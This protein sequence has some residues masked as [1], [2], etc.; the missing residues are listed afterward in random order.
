MKASLRV[1][2]A[3]FICACCHGSAGMA[4]VLSL[5]GAT[6]QTNGE[7]EASAST[8][9]SGGSKNFN[10]VLPV[11]GE[12]LN[13]AS[14]GSSAALG[15]TNVGSPSP[16]VIVSAQ[17]DVGLPPAFSPGFSNGAS[18]SGDANLEYS[19][20]VLGPTPTVP[21]LVQASG[22]LVTSAP[23]DAGMAAFL[24]FIIAGPGV[25]INDQ[26]DTTVG[27]L[28]NAEILCGSA[29]CEG[30]IRESSVYTFETD[31]LYSVEIG[32]SVL[33]S[34]TLSVASDGTVTSINAGLQSADVSMDPFFSVPADTPSA[35]DYSFVFSAGIGNAPIASI[36]ELPVWALLSVGFMIVGGGWGLRGKSAR[37][38]SQSG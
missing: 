34:G 30:S 13:G 6:Y 5:P 25:T 12:G 7:V 14:D 28:G 32:G 38:Y 9:G 8:T 36:P 18:S 24:E 31:E 4:A 35:S 23:T 16:A 29:G 26:V 22:A 20:E 27:A 11:D 3:W 10:S 2:A 17:S 37:T 19:F 33:S 1:G 15:L 21:V